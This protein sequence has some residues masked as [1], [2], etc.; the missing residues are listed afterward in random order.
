[1]DIE[2]YTMTCG[3]LTMPFPF[4]LPG[5]SGML[6]V[7]IPSYLI[8]HPRGTVLFDTGLEADLQIEDQAKRDEILGTA[9]PII[10]DFKPGEGVGERLRAFG[11]DPERIDFVINSHLHFD[12]C[13]GNA[14]IPNA[15]LVVQRREWSAGSTPELAAANGYQPRHYDL[16]HDRMEVDGEHDLFDDGSVILVPTFGHTP[17]HQSLKVKLK[18]GDVMLTADACYMRQA[19]DEMLLPD[20]IAVRDPEAML[21]NFRKLKAYESAG[22]LMLFGHDPDQWPHLNEG[23]IRRVT[24]AD[25][26]TAAAAARPLLAH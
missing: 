23:P 11:V 2:L 16:G 9:F 24:C 12:H 14:Q 7:P 20:P 8:R 22:V 10:P 3:W 19:L 4:F 13:G 21:E 1:M 6:A 26:R 15:R 25:L 17:G 18:D 5:G